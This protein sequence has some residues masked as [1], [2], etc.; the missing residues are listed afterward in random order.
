MSEKTQYVLSRGRSAFFFSIVLLIVAF[1]L[2][3]VLDWPGLNI[4]KLRLD[5]CPNPQKSSEAAKDF[6]IQYTFRPLDSIKS[7]SHDHDQDWAST[8]SIPG[9]GFLQV[10]H[11]ETFITGWTISMYHGLHCLQMLRSEIQRAKD[12][13]GMQNGAGQGK[14]STGNKQWADQARPFGDEEHVGHCIAYLA[15]V[16]TILSSF[17]LCSILLIYAV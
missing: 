3:S 2:L 13:E 15:Q 6:N 8:L 4:P 7:F 17:A 9:R 5:Y 1:T 16:I 12:L 10:Q 14:D 11:N